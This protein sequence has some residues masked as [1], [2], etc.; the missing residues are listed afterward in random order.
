MSARGWSLASHVSRSTNCS[1]SRSTS[2]LLAD[3]SQR[4]LKRPAS[5][6]AR[7]AAQRT[8]RGPIESP[9]AIPEDDP[10]AMAVV[11][12]I[13]AGDQPALGRLLQEHSG[14]GRA[15]IVDH[16]GMARSLLHIATDWPG[17]C[18]SVSET[19]RAL[20]GGGADV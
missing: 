11:S 8:K 12:A 10:L 18:P 5:A 7:A 14:L 3:R 1:R 17:H 13:R 9:Q 2:W 19:I 20:V 6:E 16:R 15:T 4:I